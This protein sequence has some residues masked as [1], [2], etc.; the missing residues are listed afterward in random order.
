MAVAETVQQIG[1]ICPS[2][3]VG[4]GISGIHGIFRLWVDDNRAL[5]LHEQVARNVYVPETI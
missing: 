1:Y 3:A 2:S 4:T 5:Q